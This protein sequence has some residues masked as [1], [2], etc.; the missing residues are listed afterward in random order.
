MEGKNMILSVLLMSLVISQIQVEAKSCCPDG[1]SRSCYNIC[2]FTGTTLAEL[3]AQL[4]SC[5]NVAGTT[6][7]PGYTN[8]IL[9]NSAQG[10]DVNRYC[11]LGCASYVCGALT[12]LQN[13]DAS[14]IVNGA[15]AQCTKAC[16]ALCTKGS[17]KAVSTA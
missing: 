12:T 17:A 11:K 4:C 10:D 15:V 5:K 6:C 16:S 14:E 1:S 13:S 2:R 7:P 9:E 3:C 8:D